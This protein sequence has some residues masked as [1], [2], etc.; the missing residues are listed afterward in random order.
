MKAEQIQFN[1]IKPNVAFKLL[2]DF[3]KRGFCYRKIGG[4]ILALYKPE[5][6]MDTFIPTIRTAAGCGSTSRVMVCQLP[7]EVVSWLRL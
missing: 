7:H 6:S 1:D 3:P 4:N 2:N 5:V